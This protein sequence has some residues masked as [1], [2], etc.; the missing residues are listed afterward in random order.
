ME[1][2]EKQEQ[3]KPQPKEG[4]Y[5]TLLMLPAG[6]ELITLGRREDIKERLQGN[7]V[8]PDPWV[9]FDLLNGNN[10]HLRSSSVIGL[11]E[12]T[13]GPPQRQNHALIADAAVLDQIKQELPVRG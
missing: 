11:V 13:L 6:T 3:E 4:D 10:I 9:D 1:L 7:I 12:G 8:D 2:N 5:I